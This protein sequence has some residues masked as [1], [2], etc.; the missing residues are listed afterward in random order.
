MPSVKVKDENS[1][2]VVFQVRPPPLASTCGK[3][4]TRSSSFPSSSVAIKVIVVEVA[5]D[6]VGVPEN[7]SPDKVSPGGNVPV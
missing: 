3:V 1:A 6:V 5:L 2:A 4:T 7:K